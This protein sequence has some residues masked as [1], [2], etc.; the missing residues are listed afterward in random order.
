M[1]PWHETLA[2]A[3]LVARHWSTVG[4]GTG[5][6]VTVTLPVVIAIVIMIVI[7]VIGWLAVTAAVAIGICAVV[8][9][10]AW[11]G[12]VP[13][14]WVAAAIVG[15]RVDHAIAV[16]VRVPAGAIAKIIG[17]GTAAARMRA[18][19]RRVRI[20][21]PQGILVRATGN[22]C[23]RGKGD[24]NFPTSF[25]VPLVSPNPEPGDI[26]T[27]YGSG[28]FPAAS[29]GRR[30]LRLLLPLADWV[31]RNDAPA[32]RRLTSRRIVRRACQASNLRGCRQPSGA[33]VMSKGMDRKKET[34]KKPKKT[35]A[36]KKAAKKAKP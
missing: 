15:I 19:V 11:V 4:T 27:G 6:G 16:V 17:R 12:V 35:K 33:H 8:H 10:V 36:E 25:H 3:D 30:R 18:V 32:P 29:A 22:A 31:I 26:L 14:A 21:Q 28:M 2:I 7:V 20:W 1:I 9:G 34:K 13:V 23:Q 24:Q 5:S